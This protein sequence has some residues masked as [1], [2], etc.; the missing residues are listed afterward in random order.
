MIKLKL[1]RL[2]YPTSANWPQCKGKQICIPF[3]LET[4]ALLTALIRRDG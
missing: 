3:I 1:Q 4:A 2:F